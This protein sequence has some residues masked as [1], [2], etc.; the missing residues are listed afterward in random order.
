MTPNPD[1]HDCFIGA[2][3]WSIDECLVHGLIR[4]QCDK[5][6]CEIIYSADTYLRMH[7]EAV[8]EA[9]LMCVRCVRCAGPWLLDAVRG[10]GALAGTPKFLELMSPAMGQARFFHDHRN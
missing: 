8:A 1:T 7:N 10:K 5:C 2:D 9:R 6:Q 3:P 4:D